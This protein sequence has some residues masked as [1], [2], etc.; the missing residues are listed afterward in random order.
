MVRPEAPDTVL[1]VTSTYGPD[2]GS[3]G[4]G[5]YAQQVYSSTNDGTSWA[6]IGTIDPSATVTTIEVAA[7]DPQRI[8]VSTF[9]GDGATRTTSIFTSKNGGQSWTETKTPFDPSTESAVYIAAVD[10]GNADLLYIRSSG[11]SRLIVSK[12]G[13]QTFAV[14]YSMPSGDEMEGFALSTDGSKVYVGGPNT[15]LF[16]APSSTLSFTQKSS[17]HVQCLATHGTD[18]WACS[19]EPSGFVAGVSQNDGSSFTPKLHLT[20]ISGPTQCAPTTT[21]GRDL[22]D[23]GRGR[24]GPVQPLR[25][26]LPQPRQLLRARRGPRAAPLGRV[27]RG[28]GVRPDRRQ[29]KQQR[30]NRERRESTPGDAGTKP[31]GG[32]VRLLWLLGRE[33]AGGAASALLA[34]GLALLALH[35]R[36]RR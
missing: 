24:G 4:G 23:D 32:R 15:G 8:Y 25:L 9:R 26:S 31:S 11:A 36:R 18:L 30:R 33:A 35:R 22:H 5:G 14:A 10:P 3:D 1:A 16:V 28:G 29:R 20:T 7:T 21:S 19:D 17:I 34:S 12:D 27:R 13:A 6:P 2:A